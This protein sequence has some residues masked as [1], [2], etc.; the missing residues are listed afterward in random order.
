MRTT[1][2]SPTIPTASDTIWL[3]T[4]LKKA[5]SGIDNKAN[6]WMNMH[7]TLATLSNMKQGSSE[8]NDYYLEQFNSNVTSVNLIHG[9]Q[10]IFQVPC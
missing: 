4:E 9:S 7:E 1:Q 10:V 5:T 3:L 8:Y 2:L 6:A